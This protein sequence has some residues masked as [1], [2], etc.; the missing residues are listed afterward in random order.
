[1]AEGKVHFSRP[2][3]LAQVRLAIKAGHSKIFL[4]ASSF[5]R[6]GLKSRKALE[7]SGAQVVLENS[8]GR[9]IEIGVEKLM[10][11]IELHRDNR[12]FRQIEKATGVPKSTVHYLVKYAERQKLRKGKDV[13]YL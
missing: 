8:R 9:P 13:V 4:P 5:T 6:M 10:E 12:T 7:D 2:P 11:I 1:M 3:T